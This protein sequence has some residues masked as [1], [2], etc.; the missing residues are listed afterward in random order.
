MGV[1]MAVMAPMGNGGSV[2][3]GVEFVEHDSSV[4]GEFNGLEF[5]GLGLTRQGRTSSDRVR[6]RQTESDR[7]L[8]A[9][10]KRMVLGRSIFGRLFVSFPSQWTIIRLVKCA[11]TTPRPSDATNSAHLCC[12]GIHV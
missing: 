2:P 11:T 8:P 3:V 7:F 5:N 6:L 12:Q 10:I 1:S 4:Q 9:D